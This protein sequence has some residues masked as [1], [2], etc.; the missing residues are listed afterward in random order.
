[1]KQ[2]IRI[3]AIVR[4][5]DRIL[6]LE[7]SGDRQELEHSPLELLS[8]K[9]EYGEQP[10]D[11]VT[12]LVHDH[13][14]KSIKNIKLTD[15]VTL[16]D[17]AD[18]HEASSLYVVYSVSLSGHKL[19]LNGDRYSAFKWASL[20]ETKSL[21]LDSVS[22]YVLGV[23]HQSTHTGS[24]DILEGGGG[25]LS[26]YAIV[27]TDGGSRGNPGLSA[28]GY[29]ITSSD[30]TVLA[31]GGE[32]IGVTNSRQA[33]YVALR[34]GIEKVLELGLKK[35]VFK[36]DNLMVVG[37]MNG[38]YKIK[39]RELWPIYDEIAELLKK[40][41]SYSFIHV[42]RELNA[43]ADSEVNRILDEKVSKTSVS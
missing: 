17:A 11:A 18:S 3:V 4:D 16:T 23:A 7:H 13:L 38:L 1:M 30:G 40:L 36:L 26:G 12:R 5:D 6:L 2:R 32:F 29:Y 9:L 41:E 10:E 33:E 14:G 20:Q 37:H 39:N 27:H 31:R 21:H 24:Q 15:V 43:E 28:A 25:E 8:G 19:H 35:V 34:V 42:K 22:S